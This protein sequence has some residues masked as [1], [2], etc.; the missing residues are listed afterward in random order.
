ME[1][2][3]TQSYTAVVKYTGQ[4]PMDGPGIGPN[5][6]GLRTDC[7]QHCCSHPKRKVR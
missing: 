4:A 6:Y 2:R 5:Q 7:S 1:V 3:E